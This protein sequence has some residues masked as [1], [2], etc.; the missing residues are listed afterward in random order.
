[1]HSGVRVCFPKVLAMSAKKITAVFFMLFLLW[2]GINACFSVPSALNVSAISGA[3]ALTSW[4]N[5][6]D[7]SAFETRF[8]KDLPFYETAVRLWSVARFYLFGEG[9]PKIVVG[10]NNVLFT[11]EEFVYDRNTRLQMRK[12][13]A[14]IFEVKK[15]L[16]LHGSRLYIVLIPAKA[17]LYADMAEE[18]NFSD[19]HYPE[20]KLDMYQ[21]IINFLVDHRIDFL[22][23]AQ[24]FELHSNPASLY[25]R[26][27]THWSPEGAAYIAGLV[28]DDIDKDYIKPSVSYQ[29][30]R[31]DV[32][33]HEGDL[34]KYLPIGDMRASSGYTSED[35]FTYETK[36]TDE[37]VSEDSLFGDQ[38]F[39][40][41]LV[42]TSYS[43]NPLWHFEGFLK[44]DLS[45]DV[46]NVA[47]EGLGPFKTMENYLA[48]DQYASS[49]PKLVIWEM[50]ERYFFMKEPE[51]RQ[52]E[53]VK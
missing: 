36:R 47:D 38:A 52:E 18:L 40:V 6:K 3:N 31:G 35:I 48:S 33:R 9:G 20:V 32:K 10:P 24:A 53:D 49:A 8:T 29:T 25:L 19:S 4:I 5:G 30:Q 7:T 41:V 23:G 17:H 39:D 51:L 44:Q 26:R 45:T 11:Q 50:P 27:D 28:A 15:K 1:M 12:N 14:E 34:L 21:D 2:A 22:D 43:A 13:L 16:R 37:N 46:L 42:G